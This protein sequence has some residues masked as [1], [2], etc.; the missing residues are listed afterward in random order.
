MRVA[1]IDYDLC[2]PD[3]CGN[4]LCARLCPVNRDGMECI[5]KHE[6]QEGSSK[7]LLPLIQTASSRN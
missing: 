3:K 7:R 5:T 6:R 2:K 4:F 1:V